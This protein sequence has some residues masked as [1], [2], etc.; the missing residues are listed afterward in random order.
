MFGRR[1][2]HRK[3]SRFMT[4]HPSGVFCFLFHDANDEYR[5][6]RIP[7]TTEGRSQGRSRGPVEKRPSRTFSNL[8]NPPPGIVTW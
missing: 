3:R 4:S 1:R 6:L 7:Q 5:L 8:P 2:A